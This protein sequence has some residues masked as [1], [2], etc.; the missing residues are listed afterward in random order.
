M[1]AQ[2]GV[3]IDTICDARR[4][5]M[6]AEESWLLLRD[7][8]EVLVA[9][10]KKVLRLRPRQAGKDAVLA[11]VLGRSATLRAPTLRMGSRFLCGWNEQ[12]YAAWLP[13]NPQA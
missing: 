10:G 11:E 3:A 7:A 4:E 6:G 1:L 2:S 8:E 13:P 5:S 12:L 9:K